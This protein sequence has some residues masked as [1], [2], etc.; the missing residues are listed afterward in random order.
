MTQE[1]FS[2]DSSGS[3]EGL[4]PGSVIH[5]VGVCGVAMAPL[6]VALADMGHRVSGSDRQFYD[7][8]GS[9]LRAS[10]V[11]LLEGYDENH[12][13]ADADLVVFANGMFRDNPEV[14]EVRRRGLAYASFPEVVGQSVVGSRHA[15][16]SCGTH[17]KTTT[18]AMIATVLHRLGL[19]PSHFVG[20]IVPGLPGSLH[21]GTG[22]FAVVEGDEY[23]T[24]FY[25]RVP[26]FRFYRARTAIVNAIE[27]DHA[28]L[29][30][31]VEDVIEE[32]RWL[33]RSLPADG[34]ALVCVDYPHVRALVDEEGSSI[35]ARVV[36]FG[37]HESADYR[38]VD[39][40]VHGFGQVVELASP[41]HD[42]LH[43][44]LPV[45]GAYNA[46]NG[47]ACL[48]A[49]VENGFSPR[50]VAMA[51]RG[52]RTVQRR[53][54]VRFDEGITLVEDF[55]HHPT[56][57]AGTVRAV[58]EA[59]P[60]RS[61]WAVFEPRSNTSRRKVFEEPYRAAFAEAEHVLLADVRSESRMND[62]VELLDVRELAAA[63]AAEGKDVRALPDPRSI[64]DL[65]LREV[66]PHDVVLL[67]SNGSFGDLPA[68]L[69]A[70]LRHRKAA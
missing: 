47:V 61:I 58:A 13:P 2:V 35:A 31:R 43:L 55:A 17:G 20:G 60:G 3:L 52:F 4:A 32:F 40:K 18:T 34:L 33:L 67:M 62:G 65:L 51:L 57:V 42:G 19:D 66:G 11:R 22:D 44:E 16:V 15:I 9:L 5:V 1:F 41:I 38:L 14:Q 7:P 36:R 53:Q 46:L 56:A 64:E 21:V 30:P 10:A 54:Q 68:R 24:A 27:F 29:Y 25:A 28:D 12:V 59:F 63:M 48:A 26:K 37:W 69:E 23:H 8:M 45:P 6:A 39:R 50:E 49:L 70:A